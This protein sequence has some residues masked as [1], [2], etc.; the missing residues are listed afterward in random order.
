MEVACRRCGMSAEVILVPR[1]LEPPLRRLLGS[2]AYPFSARGIG[3]MLGTGSILAVA[4]QQGPAGRAIALLLVY[5]AGLLVVR[6]TIQGREDLPDPG[7]WGRAS[8]LVRAMAKAGVATL[9]A[10][11]PF[12]AWTVKARGVFA[13]AAPDEAAF[14]LRCA[15]HPAGVA[16]LALAA[17]WIPAATMMA[18]ADADFAETVNPAAAARQVRRVAIE[19]AAVVGA[20]LVLAA[21]A[22]GMV[23]VGAV[24]QQVMPL[25]VVPAVLAGTFAL[26][27]PLAGARLSG[28]LVYARGPEMGLVSGRTS[29]VPALGAIQPAEE[30]APAPETPQ[31]EAREESE[32]PAAEAPVS[33]PDEP[34]APRREAPPEPA[35]ALLRAVEKARTRTGTTLPPVA[36]AAPAQRTA[37]SPSVPS[38]AAAPAPRAVS[39]PSV[40]PVAA[41]P[42]SR[43]A[44]SP[45]VPP[46]AASP[47][48]SSP[49]EPPAATIAFVPAVPPAPAPASVSPAA[50]AP[51]PPPAAAS[52]PVEPASAAPGP[53]SPSVAPAPARGVAREKTPPP[54]EEPGS[55]A[56]SMP[57]IDPAEQKTAA[58][59]EQLPTDPAMPPVPGAAGGSAARAPTDDAIRSLAASG[60]YAELAAAYRTRKGGVTFLNATALKGLAKA[61]VS[62][63]DAATASHALRRFASEFPKDPG[64]PDAL[65]QASA[66][67]REKLGRIEE[68]D[69]LAALLQQRYP[70]SPAAQRLRGARGGGS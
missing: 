25:P 38:V 57:A 15:A 62:V 58:A 69:R 14:L 10:L 13:A 19:Y 36:P 35:P 59:M 64:A 44:S 32:G 52:A 3:L 9:L 60:R 4:V 53:A 1:P 41:A 48:A 50:P 8:D 29:L 6:S 49:S 55:R 17:A 43:T 22:A 66:L 39:S 54:P 20:L 65:A 26:C 31:P 46:F 16:T 45:S 40:P 2:L 61:A 11:A 23:V 28:L 42:A 34:T 24:L 68:A 67:A 5:A 21:L 63:G 56:D 33:K 70:S 27:A 12:V 37:S 47:A 18:A 7:E 51:V 30:K